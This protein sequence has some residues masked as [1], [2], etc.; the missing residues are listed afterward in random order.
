MAFLAGTHSSFMSELPGGEL[1][2]EVVHV[3]LDRGKVRSVEFSFAC[4]AVCK[5]FL[6]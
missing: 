2:K 6:V 3:D 1:E 5:S 4:C